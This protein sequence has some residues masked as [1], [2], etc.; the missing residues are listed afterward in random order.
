MYWWT[1][2]ISLITWTVIC[3]CNWCLWCIFSFRALRY[4][5]YYTLMIRTSC[6]RFSTSTNGSRRSKFLIII[7]WCCEW[8][9]LSI[10]TRTI[11]C[12]LYTFCGYIMSCKI[13]CFEVS[14]YC[15]RTWW[16][17]LFI[18]LVR[19]CTGCWILSWC[20]CWIYIKCIIVGRICCAFSSCKISFG[21][22]SITSTRITS[23][24]ISYPII[25]T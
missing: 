20:R 25:I 17:S 5:I 14:T 23:S 8:L 12:P 21:L 11:N 15:F 2:C 19:S 6:I 7:T 3:R 9:T 1:K 16:S 10:W 13:T 4:Y 18:I 24:R 22:I